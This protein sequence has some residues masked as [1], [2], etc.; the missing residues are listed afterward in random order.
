M[1]IAVMTCAVLVLI[2]AGVAQASFGIVPGSFK[3][4]ALNRDGSIDTQAGS[5]P[6]E[7][8]VTFAFN[9][10]SEKEPEG[11]V[12]DIDVN[13]PPGLVGDATTVPRCSDEEFAGN[14]VKCSGNTQVGVLR[15]TLQGSGRTE[16][17]LYNLEPSRGEAAELGTTVDGFNVLENVSVRTGSD[18][19]LSVDTSNIPATGIVD[20]SETV[21]G[22]P[23]DSSHDPE[24]KCF[25]GLSIV[26]GCASGVVPKSFLTL[27]TVCDAPPIARMDVDSRETPGMFF[28]DPPETALSVDSGG[29]P[30]PL[31]GCER[32]T[33]EPSLKVAPDTQAADTPAGLTAEVKVGQAALGSPEGLSSADL[34]NTM[35]ELPE[36]VVINPG[37]AAGL[38][39][40]PYSQDGVG[41]EGPPSCPNASKVGTVSI[42]T[43][44]LEEELEGNVYV[45]PASPPNIELLVAPADPRAGVYVKLIGKVHMDAAT[46]QLTTTFT[47]TP[48][49]P[50]TRFRLS[51]SGGAQ[52]ALST[53]VSCGTYTTNADFTP[54]G[55]P[56]QADDLT[57][58]SF[59]VTT[60]VGGGACPAS[61]PFTPSMI[62]GATTD[63]AG[64][65]TDFSLLLSR[66]DDQQRVSALRFETPEGL[67]GMISKVPLCPEPQASEGSCS[68]TS[69]IGHTVVEAGPGPYPLVVP[70]PGEPPA[71]IYLTGPYR[72]A[73]YGLSIV[74]PLHV[75]PFTLQTQIVRAKIEVDPLTS[76]LTVSTDPLPQ[77]IDGVPA[78]LRAINAVIDRPGFMFNPTDCSPQEFSGDA[79]SDG[80]VSTTISS[81]FQMGSCQ[82]LRFKPNFKVSTNGRTSRKD[83]AG[84]TA[85]ILYPTGALEHN[86]AS[87]QSNIASVKVDLP[88]QL[89]SRLTTLQHSCTSAQFENNP[90]GCPAASVVGHASAITPVLPVPV[91]GPAY[92]VSYGAAKFPELVIV[93]Q[94]YGVTIDLHGETFINSRTNIT[95][96][97]FR[98]V[99]DVPITSFE[100]SLPEGPNSALVAPRGKLCSSKLVMPTAF[101]GHNGA[102]IHQNTP[103]MVTGCPKHAG[104]VPKK[105]H[106]KK[107]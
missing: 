52:A 10:N 107:R 11:D 22:V 75:G 65:Y 32:L 105:R 73:P 43:P 62:A 49:L 53:P 35:V 38:Q 85:K 31:T 2:S 6:F 4:T 101:T 69:Q 98:R 3:V 25:V 59:T 88:K 103:I 7:Y 14:S 60:G 46:G 20:V 99:P 9:L 18:Y 48:Q 87:G 15:V 45:L 82:S 74:V 17:P 66:P 96:S 34:K 102:V 79:T 47:E 54:W 77:I 90:A 84:L 28:P 13:L 16:Q 86:Q 58:D 61:L 76:R 51:F 106:N 83:G 1:T 94:G 93:L 26:N 42:K 55:T 97:T 68:A 23:A 39:A 56:F 81:H 44:L 67:L 104:H 70:Q 5:H 29:N 8:N 36:G 95:S 71:P 64:G 21:W 33:L 19:G 27:P 24:R 91:S 57:S 50:F 72:G 100:L 40:C 12:R 80:G 92:F 89:P 30:I 78:D 63:Q 41:T 37:Q